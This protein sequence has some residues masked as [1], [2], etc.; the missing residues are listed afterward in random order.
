MEDFLNQGWFALQ[1]AWY[2]AWHEVSGNITLVVVAASILL[3]L[4]IFLS[5]TLRKR[6]S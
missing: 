5:P 2:R 1:V 4:W 6:G 3:L